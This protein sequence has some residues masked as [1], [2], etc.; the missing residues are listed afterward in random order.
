MFVAIVTLQGI[1]ILAVLGLLMERLARNIIAKRSESRLRSYEPHILG[2]LIDS[3]D[4]A[5]LIQAAGA[6]DR[7]IILEKLLQQSE[8][9]KGIDKDHMTDV[10]QRLGLVRQGTGGLASGK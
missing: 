1:V 6:K 7:E 2:H 3:A 4:I 10:F 8:Q 9:L 5:H